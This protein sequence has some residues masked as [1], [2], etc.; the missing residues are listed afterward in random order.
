[1]TGMPR[2]HVAL[3]AD[4]GKQRDTVPRQ[5][6][7]KNSRVGAP[8]NT[9]EISDMNSKAPLSTRKR[10]W[11][12][13]TAIVLLVYCVSFAC[14]SRIALARCE[15]YGLVG[16]CF[17]FWYGDR[18]FTEEHLRQEDLVRLFY[19]PLIVVDEN[20]FGEGPAPP[21]TTRFD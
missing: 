7:G 12:V 14:W 16:Y 21:P 4:A 8:Q 2:S 19:Y 11:L 17:L 1:V 15:A 5:Q 20:V 6:A 9:T 13:A 18:M 10:R 3:Q